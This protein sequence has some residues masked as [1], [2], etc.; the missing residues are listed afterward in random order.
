[1]SMTIVGERLA[2]SGCCDEMND[3]AK[4]AR[5]AFAHLE[6]ILSHWEMRREPDPARVRLLRAARDRMADAMRAAEDAGMAFRDAAGA[7][8]M[9]GIPGEVTTDV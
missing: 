3:V 7:P 9:D 8:V 5:A 4:A 2:L 6:F 1:M